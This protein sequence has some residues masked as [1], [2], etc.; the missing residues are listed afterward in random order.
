MLFDTVWSLRKVASGSPRD[1]LHSRIDELIILSWHDPES[2][3]EHEHSRSVSFTSWSELSRP[4]GFPPLSAQS[5][6]ASTTQARN[7][8]INESRKSLAQQEV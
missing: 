5:I 8:R 1:S 6:S 7:D 4:T 2:W 3:L